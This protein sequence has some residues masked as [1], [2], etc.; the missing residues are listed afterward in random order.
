MGLIKTRICVGFRDDDG[1]ERIEPSVIHPES[2]R[3]LRP[4]NDDDCSIE[5]E[6]GS[7]VLVFASVADTADAWQAAL[8]EIG[9]I[10]L[11]TRD[12]E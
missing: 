5:F 8:T 7:E 3:R 10:T 11:H 9:P 12:E 2:I 4:C 6:D 1:L